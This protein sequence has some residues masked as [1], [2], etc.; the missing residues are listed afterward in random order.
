MVLEVICLC[1]TLPNLKYN[2]GAERALEENV[3]AKKM[4]GSTY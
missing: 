3:N 1:I 2:N 4:H